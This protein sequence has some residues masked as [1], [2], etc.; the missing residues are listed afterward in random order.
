MGRG[1]QETVILPDVYAITEPL[2]REPTKNSRLIMDP[3]RCFLT[4]SRLEAAALAF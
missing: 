1:A 4:E 3:G 2:D